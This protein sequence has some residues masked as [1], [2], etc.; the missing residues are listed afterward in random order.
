MTAT[1]ASAVGLRDEQREQVHE[2]RPHGEAPEQAYE[3]A[4]VQVP[5]TG[6]G[7]RLHDVTV[8]FVTNKAFRIDYVD[9]FSS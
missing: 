9:E 8:L 6:L 1:A 5:T 3:E 4:E 2:P 7:F